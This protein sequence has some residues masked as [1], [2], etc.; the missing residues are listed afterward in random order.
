MIG[1]DQRIDEIKRKRPFKELIIISNIKPLLAKSARSGESFQ[2]VSEKGKMYKL[3]YCFT[4]KAARNIEKNVNLFPKAF[5]KLY[6]REGKFLLFEWVDG[7]ELAEGVTEIDSYKIGKL[8]GELHELNIKTSSR[9]AYK[10]LKQRFAILEKAKVFD[11]DTFEQIK[12]KYKQLRKKLKVDF[13]LEIYDA[14]PKNFVISKKGKVYFIDQGGM[15]HHI[16][17]MGF[18][19]L[20][21][22]TFSKDQRLIASFWKG[23]NEHHS[24]DYFDRDYQRLVRILTYI[25]LI[26]VRVKEKKPVEKWLMGA[27]KKEIK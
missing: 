17:G 5:P 23:Y 6:L 24:R 21:D 2:I 13:L 25:F 1:M 22:K 19:A 27:M 26:S 4:L 3:R 11:P 18:S 8:L 16:K 20:L 10:E 14:G 15:G 7:K 12:D 9:E